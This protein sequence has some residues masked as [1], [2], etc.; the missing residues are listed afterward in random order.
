MGIF[1]IFSYYSDTAS[2]FSIFG[3]PVFDALDFLTSNIMM[4]IGAI[5]F[6]FF[7]GYKLKKESLY[8][9]FGEFMGKAFFE[10]WYF[11]LRYIVPIAICAIMIYQIAGK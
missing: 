11:A 2:T 4:P 10:I 9:L 3:K 1:C 8:L 5:I 7:V 6:S